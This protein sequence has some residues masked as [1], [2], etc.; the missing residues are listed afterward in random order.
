MTNRGTKRAL[1]L[2]LSLAMLLGLLP[3]AAFAA[4]TDGP[5]PNHPAHDADCGYIEA[6]EG[7]PCKHE[8]GEHDDVCGYTEGTPEIPCDLGC[9]E[10]DETGAV[11]HA[12]DCAYTPAVAGT[13][14]A[15]LA[16][17]RHKVNDG[18]AGREGPEGGD[19]DC[20]YVAAVEGHSCDHACE[21]CAPKDAGNV[22]VT[23]F[24]EL[25]DAVKQ[26]SVQADTALDDL[27]LP[28]TLDA[29]GYKVN[30]GE[31]GREGPLGGTVTDDTGPAPEPEAITIAGVTWEVLD[32]DGS[33]AV[34]EVDRTSPCTYWLRAVL[35]EGYTLDE[36]VALPEIE[37]RCG[38]AFQTNGSA[39]GAFTVTGGT[40]DT[41][42][43][44]KD[45]TLTILS[46]AVLTIAN[47]NPN[48]P[49]I[50]DKI[51]VESGANADITLAG[52]NIQFNDGSDGTPGTC[53]FD[54][55]GAEVA[56]TLADGTDNILK[57][58]WDRAGLKAPDGSKLTIGGSGNLETAVGVD[59]S[60]TGGAGIGG[61][62][63][64]GDS[65]DSCTG[66]DITITG[67]TITANGGV[68]AGIGGGFY[69]SGGR[70][71][72]TGGTIDATGGN[73]GGA[74]IGGG[75][76]GGGGIVAISGG[77]VTANGGFGA[78]IGGG[79]GGGNGGSVTISGGTVKAYGSYGAGIGGGEGENGGDGGTITISGGDVTAIGLLYGA[80]IGGGFG[81]SDGGTGGNGG[82]ITISGGTVTAKGDKGAGIGGG[83]GGGDRNGT[84]GASGD[85]AIQDNAV[86]F[87][88]SSDGAEHIGGGYGKTG[89]GDS[90]GVDITGGVIFEDKDGKVYGDVTLP[91]DLTI[92]KGSTLE[93]PDGST[94]TI[95]D[96]ATLTNEG[97]IT[98]SGTIN[99]V[100]QIAN[101]AGAFTVTGGIKGRD[102]T[103]AA[104]VLT[105]KTGAAL[106]I[107]NTKPAAPTTD[108]IVV[109]SGF[110]ADITLA[111]VNIDV[112]ST[113]GACAFD[114]TDAEVALTLADGTDNILK[115]GDKRAGVEAP[116]GS[117]LTIGGSG[118]LE[119]TGGTS[120]AGIGGGFSGSIGDSG[121]IIT[122]SGG[123]VKAT[124]GTD[125]AGI[126]GGIGGNG[127]TIAI[128]GGTVTATGGTGAGIGGGS[129]GDG[130]IISIGGGA[131]VTATSGSGTGIGGGVAGGPFGGGAGGDIT[132]QDN[133]VVF[134]TNSRNAG[135]HIGSAAGRPGSNVA[136][137]GGVIFEGTAGAVY[138]D[139]T[140]P[141]NLT[142]PVGYQLTI[143]S[144][145]S[146][147]VPDGVTLT[148]EGKIVGSGALVNDG[149]TIIP[150]DSEIL[151][152]DGTQAEKTCGAFTV[153]GPVSSYT[154]NDSAHT[155]TIHGGAVLTIANTNPNT[156]TI[157]DKIVVESGAQNVR[158]TLDGVNIDVS[159]TTDAC[160][161]DMTG[162]TVTL[163]LADGPNNIL[164]S[165]NIH[166]GLEA[167]AGSTLTIGGSGR[168]EATG[169]RWGAGIGGGTGGLGSYNG[170]SGGTITISG[171]TVTATGDGGAGIGGGGAI[172]SG[173]SGG[174]I[175]INGG[176]VTAMGGNGAGIG[177]GFG[178]AASGGSGGEIHIYGNATVTATSTSGVGIGGGYG[179]S[180]GGS[181]GEIQIY[182][183]ATVTATGGQGAGIGG[184]NGITAGAGGDIAIQNN[185]VVFATGVGDADHIGGGYGNTGKGDSS[186][187]KKTGG[188]IFEGTAGAVYGDVTLPG[189]VTLPGDLTIPD[190]STLTIPD[191][192]TLTI[193]DGKTLI[194]DH[195][196][197]NNGAI[198]G[199][200]I[201]TGRGDFAKGEYGQYLL[202]VTRAIDTPAM[203]SVTKNSVTLHA[204]PTPRRQDGNTAGMP[205]TAPPA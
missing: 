136:K 18:E 71:T 38:V 198:D 70:I 2:C 164:K 50:E 85:I 96:S 165:G 39:T 79:S 33:P 99:G 155:L 28:A 185:A 201:L 67:G 107:K 19:A 133:A 105:I 172:G 145:A 129:G 161:F 35:P 117:K 126:G 112:S 52:V 82:T 159:G 192:F 103:Y 151:V 109:E 92:P 108:K 154:Y 32:E 37:L 104:N 187:V 76:G 29:S 20:G 203:A 120:G 135:H 125:G 43:T 56:L 83:N 188:V 40:P 95:P 194:N 44:Y 41:D 167:P 169:G 25:D 119:A 156:P 63:G 106:T 90:S 86:V 202:K 137:I 102:Y 13:P 3:T 115:S 4:G 168:L 152:T 134:A 193:P 12:A 69:G 31:A 51:V 143:P 199:T 75:A 55:T 131:R 113:D 89:N 60:G 175:T 182:G 177:G 88:A 160:A 178:G 81:Y 9:T 158:L 47:T 84:G 34:Y 24:D 91:G 57:S 23:A 173:G 146:L 36:D 17:G 205:A 162:A 101:K 180:N 153:T 80:G 26:Q 15:H 157:E 64:D 183:N 184:C 49:T 139:V 78:G 190:S 22:T 97:E 46:G 148:N 5:C 58:G 61:E 10:L 171:G 45:N 114:M 186:G 149:G 1:A 8:L 124:G 200:G 141:D 59:G 100:G 128:N 121:G 147:T 130:E 166:A 16:E 93:I 195:T 132:I 150:G 140:L 174:T 7:T 204:V 14:C 30:D 138:G 123:T 191:G 48:T 127:G 6:V 116:E 74:G 111:G 87:A 11:R 197:Q 62:G 94:L 170:G 142:I 42:Y 68:G 181:G 122:I 179:S 144:D 196:L 163:T 176:T 77:T 73:G 118:K 72:I 53:A 65:G 27:D 110:A 54:M 66:G 21:L 189:N 98:G